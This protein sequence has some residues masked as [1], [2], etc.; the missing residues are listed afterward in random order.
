MRHELSELRANICAARA[1]TVLLLNLYADSLSSW[2]QETLRVALRV[3]L[4]AHQ[5]LPKLV[6]LG[7]VSKVP[8]LSWLGV[9]NYIVVN[10][11]CACHT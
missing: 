4:P 7:D 10:D 2:F 9:E 6:D 5:D 1:D 11:R 3:A 8:E